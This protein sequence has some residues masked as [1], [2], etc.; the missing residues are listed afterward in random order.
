MPRIETGPG[1]RAAVG[2]GAI[3]LLLPLAAPLCGQAPYAES[4]REPA[5][6]EVQMVDRGPA[7]FAFEPA[8]IEVR[9]GD[10]IVWVQ[11]GVQPHNVQFTKGPGE[12]AVEA[13]PMSP[14]LLTKGQRYELRIDGQFVPGKYEYV[15]TPHAAMGMTGTITVV[16]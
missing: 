2:V 8:D 3:V 9:L 11:R 7:E 4:D 14:F 5:V 13:L 6:I 16:P 10:R 15:C 1:W 12:Y